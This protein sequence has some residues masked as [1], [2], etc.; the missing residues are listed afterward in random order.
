LIIKK[1]VDKKWNTSKV[2]QSS[3]APLSATSPHSAAFGGFASGFSLLSGVDAH[4]LYFY[5][6]LKFLFLKNNAKI[7][8]QITLA[9]L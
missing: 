3:S 6:L 5:Q 9:L 1:L 7:T 8:I 2:L 4:R